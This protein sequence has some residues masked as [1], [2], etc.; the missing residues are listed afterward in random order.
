MTGK[1]GGSPGGNGQRGEP[2]GLAKR[3]TLIQRGDPAGHPKKRIGELLIDAGLITKADLQEALEVQQREGGKIVD[4]LISL[5]RIEPEQFLQFLARQ[6]GIPS[7][8]LASY[9]IPHSIVSLVPR[10]LAVKHELVPIDVLGKLL[11]VA[12]V[13]PLDSKTIAELEQMTS[14]RVKALLCGAKDVRAALNRYYPADRAGAPPQAAPRPVT[15]EDIAS[16]EGPMRLQ[17]AAR[18]I[19]RI[20]ALPALP[21]TVSRIRE[22]TGDPKVTVRMVADILSMDP[23]VAAKVLSVANSAAYGFAHRV[24]DLNLAVSLMGLRETYSIVLSMAVV[25]VLRKSE[26]FDYRSFWKESVL[27]ASAARKVAEVINR[28]DMAGVFSAGLLHNLG[29]LVLVEVASDAYAKIPRDLRGKEL[30]QAE[31][32]VFGLSHSEAGYELAHHWGLPEDINEAIRFHHTPDLSVK[33]RD[34]VAVVAV[35]AMMVQ[36]ELTGDGLHES[37]IDAHKHLF[38]MIRVD[39]EHIQTLYGEIVSSRDDTL[40]N[41][42]FGGIA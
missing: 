34:M 22:A 28:K 7:I 26:V 38:E 8:D 31:E 21:E 10:E 12:M 33:S 36:A 32:A 37:L 41:A 15:E 18:L 39:A 30:V 25:D 3:G 23:P 5:G 2:A 20:S 4:V 13:C 1:Q 11:T 29:R 16:L 42:I 40:H 9:D 19:R 17:N 14:L 35:A 24:D 6:P 27:C